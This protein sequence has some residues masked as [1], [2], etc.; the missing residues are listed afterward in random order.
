MQPHAGPRRSTRQRRDKEGRE[1]KEGGRKAPKNV[2]RLFISGDQRANLNSA[3]HCPQLKHPPRAKAAS[4]RDRD[5]KRQEG[6]ETDRDS[7]SPLR[8][9]M[10]ADASEMQIKS[11]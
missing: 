10:I 7:D 9:W 6:I 8:G 5:P 4:A 2:A 1:E 3:R 11:L